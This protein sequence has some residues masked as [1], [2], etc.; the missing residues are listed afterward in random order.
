MKAP[1]FWQA[2]Q[3]GLFAHAL[4]PFGWLY[5]SLTI[6]RLKQSGWRA[7]VPVISIGNFTVGGAGKTPTA[8]ALAQALIARG[9]RPFF[10]TRGYGGRLKAPVLVDLSRHSAQDVGDE[11]LLLAEIAP[12]VM[13][14]NRAEGARLA[15]L[16]KHPPTCFILDDALQNP[17]LIKDVSIAVVDAGY[18]IGNGQCI[19]AGP[20]RAPVPAMMPH[21]DLLLTLGVGAAA[22]AV[23]AQAKSVG[24]LCCSSQLTVPEWARL[25]V[26]G[27]RVFA[28]A[29]IGRPEKFFSTLRDCGAEIVK[30]RHY[31]DHHRFSDFEAE[32]LMLE[33]QMLS[34]KLVTTQKD[35]V[36]LRGSSIQADLAEACLALPVFLMLEDALIEKVQASLF[37]CR[38]RLS[39][40]SGLA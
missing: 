2:G 5:G 13:S 35:H 22:Q 12:T 16:Q 20:L 4:M 28:F 23:E 15:L 1:E 3:R 6:L 26:Q 21:V 29:G 27:Q 25:A 33:A 38:N 36:R 32:A 10:L 19:P 14:R 39:T 31:P 40:A 9:E 17:H 8:L 34:A 30:T 7:P 37:S 18:G 11:A 24:K